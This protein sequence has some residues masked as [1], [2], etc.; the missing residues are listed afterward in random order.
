MDGACQLA[1]VEASQANIRYRHVT[2][3]REGCAIVGALLLLP[4][5]PEQAKGP[6]GSPEQ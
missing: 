4:L 2:I 6:S 5:P 3:S 1:A